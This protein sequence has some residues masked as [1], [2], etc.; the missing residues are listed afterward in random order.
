MQKALL[1]LSVI[2][3][4]AVGFSVY[5]A[6]QGQASQ[7]PSHIMD[8]WVQWK[9]T[10]QP[11][12]QSGA[13]ESYRLGVFAQNY[14]KVRVSN[15]NPKHTFT[16][17]LNKFA[18]LSADEFKKN[19][20]SDNMMTQEEFNKFAAQ[21][22]HKNLEL[23]ATPD[24]F[25]WDQQGKITP[26]K[27]QGQC[28][29]CWA[30]SVVGGLEHQNIMKNGSA[31]NLS[32]QVLVDCAK[33]QLLPPIPPNM[34][35]S[36]GNPIFAYMWTKHNGVT[37]RDNYPYT[38]RDGSCQSYDKNTAYYNPSWGVNI[39]F[40]PSSLKSSIVQRATSVGV[41]AEGLQHYTGGIFN[42]DCGGI[43]VDHAV[44]AVGYGEENGQKFWRIKNSWAE[45]WG[46]KGYFRLERSDSIGTG[47]CAVQ[48]QTSYPA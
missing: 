42:G 21:A 32:E 34:G 29:S 35:C 10:Y 2:S 47:K 13:H 7:Y 15:A 46:E 17:G 40:S 4:I 44:L 18:D 43:Q 8:A 11:G 24:S 6:S 23:A 48:T 37:D 3:A 25:D 22:D 16:S 28:G 20:L 1:A 33:G 26:V 39:P 9:K 14:E 38:A 41:I 5:K 30:F 27:D 31:R 19:Y 45:A 36:G 12:Y